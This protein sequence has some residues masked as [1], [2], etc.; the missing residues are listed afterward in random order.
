MKAESFKVENY[1][2][3]KRE[4]RDR[5]KSTQKQKRTKGPKPSQSIVD[6]CSKKKR[7]KQSIE[8]V[9]SKVTVTAL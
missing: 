6:F 7:I 2:G 8:M 3:I 1:S 9:C 5:N 4:L